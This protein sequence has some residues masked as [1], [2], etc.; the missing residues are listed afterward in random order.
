MQDLSLHS[1]QR[2]NEGRTM[3]RR[4]AVVAVVPLLLLATLLL[5]ASAGDVELQM[6]DE[7]CS[8]LTITLLTRPSKKI[9]LL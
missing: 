9:P 5:C 3:G 7:I 2:S 6:S 4:V 8:C 1:V